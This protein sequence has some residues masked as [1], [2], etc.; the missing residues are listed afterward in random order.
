MRFSRCTSI[1]IA[2]FCLA[3]PVVVNSQQA[4]SPPAQPSPEAGQGAQQRSDYVLGPD[5]EIIIR[6][7]DAEEIS[8]KPIRIDGTGNIS[9]P[10]IGRIRASGLTIRQLEDQ[11][12]QKLAVYIFEP[13][14]S[15]LVTA[16]RSQPVSVIGSVNRPGTLQLEGHKSLI[17]VLALAGGLAADAGSVVKITR[18]AEYGKIPLPNATPDES[19]ERYIAEVKLRSLMEARRPEDNIMI[20]P[21]DVLS[22]PRGQMIYVVGEVRKSGGFVIGDRESISLIQAIAM[23]EGLT[24]TASPKQARIIRPTA[25]A[26][27]TEI[28]INLRDIMAGKKV[29]VPLQADDIILVPNSAA[30]SSFKRT[31]DTT[32]STLTSMVIY[33]GW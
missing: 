6:A 19:G 33:R 5:D 22:V 13:Q 16:Y 26:K 1:L 14:V 15:V 31:L 23:A 17:E 28:P 12:R 24:P 29:D 4:Q 21:N 25:G 18:R 8:N 9:F 3:L 30:K 2:L 27:R 7:L 20:M 10:M 32:L 11:I